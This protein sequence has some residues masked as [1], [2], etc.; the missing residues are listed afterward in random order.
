MKT[1]LL[2]VHDDP[3]Q[4]ARLQAA[5]D[6]ARG[7]DGHL[8]CLHVSVPPQ[9]VAFEV[10]SSAAAIA[11]VQA[12]ERDAEL[13]N[14]H[15][16]EARLASEDVAWTWIDTTGYP[17]PELERAAGLADLI[18]LSSGDENGGS[19]WPRQLAG[20]VAL[21]ADRPVLA[22]PPGT[23]GFDPG[24]TAL[25]AWDGSREAK[26][27]LQAALPLLARAAETVLFAIDGEDALHGAEEAARYLSQHG[28]HARIDLAPD[29]QTPV[30]ERI[31]DKAHLI[32][33]GC[34]V[35]G[36]YGRK[37]VSEAIFG[38]VTRGVIAHSDVPL[39]LTH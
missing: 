29:N 38:G 39:L 16:I 37:P 5:L 19:V 27:A 20:R 9:P 22:V 10:Y 11:S 17:E 13:A 36:A 31:L 3:G 14:R 24:R 34:I 33:A 15:R 8:T 7:F 2:L 35:M 21:R 32:G 4:E 12:D 28:I 18:V 6:V 25:V 23:R 26:D 1:I 30:H